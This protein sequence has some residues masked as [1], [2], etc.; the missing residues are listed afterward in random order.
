[1]TSNDIAAHVQAARAAQQRGDMGAAVRHYEN[2]LA[3]QPGSP[4]ILNSLGMIALATPDFALA[5]RHFSEAIKSDSLSPVLLVNL[6]TAQRG[7]GDDAKEREA[8]LRVLDIDQSNL[9]ANLR[10]AE[11]HE[12]LGEK[13]DAMRRWGA[14]VGIAQSLPERAPAIETLIADAQG[15]L[16][17]HGKELGGVLEAGLAGVK[18]ETASDESKRFDVCM[19]AALGRRRIY[20][21]EC[22][23]LHFPFLPAAEFF[24]DSYFPWMAEIEARTAAISAEFLALWK[25]PEDFVPYVA[26]ESGTPENKWSA[27]DHSLDWSTFFLWRHGVRNDEACARC[28]ET[29]KAVESLPISDIPGRSPTVFFSV[30]K[31]HTRLPAHTGVTNVRSIVHL[32]LVVPEQCGFRVGGESREW[33]VGKAF[34]F[35]DTIEHEAWNDSGEA[36]AVLIFDVW[37]PYLTPAEQKLLQRFFD[38]SNSSSYGQGG[39]VD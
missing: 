3:L 36:R 19:D 6:A 13:G 2:A 29:A 31:P 10:L 38:V 32:P 27:L 25:K 37:N 30:L 18:A 7:L 5:A 11:L 16:I 20:V 33:K 17:R 23:G 1:M 12:R 4:Q 9:T 15:H 22:A 14:V 39:S 21:N 26:M 35:D 24:D 8:L 34:A 28:P